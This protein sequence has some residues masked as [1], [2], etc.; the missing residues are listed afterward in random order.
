MGWD[1]NYYLEEF[2]PRL[3]LE[4]HNFHVSDDKLNIY[5]DLDKIKVYVMNYLELL[6]AE[7]LEMMINF[8]NYEEYM[9]KKFK[10]RE[11]EEHRELNNI[12]NMVTISNN[13]YL[14]KK[15]N[16]DL[17]RLWNNL[18]NLNNF[19]ILK[20]MTEKFPRDINIMDVIN[21]IRKRKLNDEKSSRELLRDM[22]LE[23]INQKKRID[24]DIL[25]GPFYIANDGKMLL[26]SP[27]EKELLDIV[28]TWGE[29]DTD[30]I[31]KIALL[32]RWN[33]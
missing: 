23:R 22:I 24:F 28:I 6:P 8:M 33:Y 31:I 10:S 4:Q 14:I 30:D 13:L 16:I 25:K 29:I 17:S 21:F 18:N 32:G 27:N 15:Y 3:K 9:Q 19:A 12:L 1:L 26:N 20:F 11:Y 5:F 7:L 2:I